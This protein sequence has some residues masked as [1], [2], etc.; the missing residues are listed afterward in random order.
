M[1][2]LPQGAARPEALG[3]QAVTASMCPGRG[4]PVTGWQRENGD[5]VGILPCGCWVTTA[6][7]L[8]AMRARGDA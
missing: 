1:Q 8:P 4:I 7:A 3:V 5:S 2:M 6:Q